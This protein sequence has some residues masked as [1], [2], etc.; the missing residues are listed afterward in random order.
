MQP[1]EQQHWHLCFIC[2]WQQMSWVSLRLNGQM[3]YS[4][5]CKTFRIGIDLKRFL[6]H[7]NII[8][9]INPYPFHGT[10]WMGWSYSWGSL[11]EFGF[12]ELHMQAP[13]PILW[14]G[15][16]LYCH[17]VLLFFTPFK[18]IVLF[19]KV[20]CFFYQLAYVWFSPSKSAT[21]S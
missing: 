11:V 21:G 19:L 6:T 3:R 16:L 1:N 2:H 8:N 13:L 5:W 18:E 9:I 20:P 4:N 14:C 10:P 17:G 12:Q 15:E 7:D